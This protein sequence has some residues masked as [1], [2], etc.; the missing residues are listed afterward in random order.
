MRVARATKCRC[1]HEEGKKGSSPDLFFLTQD[2]SEPEGSEARTFIL[3]LVRGNSLNIS[4][5]ALACL[6]LLVFRRSVADELMKG[7]LRPPA[8]A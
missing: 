8:C 2:F 4:S 6:A 7:R 5:I 1:T 3:S